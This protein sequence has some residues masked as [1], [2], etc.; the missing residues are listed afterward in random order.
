MAT[1]V[2][3]HP[4]AARRTLRWSSIIAFT[5]ATALAAAG[6]TADDLAQSGK[7]IGEEDSEP[8]SLVDSIE[9]LEELVTPQEFPEDQDPGEIVSDELL[10][11]GAAHEEA[12]LPRIHLTIASPDGDLKKRGETYRNKPNKDKRYQCV[13][14]AQGGSWKGFDEPMVVERVS[15]GGS[16]RSCLEE[17][18]DPELEVTYTLPGTTDL[19]WVYVKV[20]DWG[21]NIL[22]C[23]VIDPISWKTKTNSSWACDQQWLQDNGHGWNPMP[24]VRFTDKNKVVQVTDAVEAQ[25]IL[26]EYCSEGQPSC[27]FNATSQEVISPDESKWRL[28][29]YFDNCG[30][31]RA[32]SGKHI[33]ED[34]VGHLWSIMVGGSLAVGGGKEKTFTVEVKGEFEHTWTSERTY[35]A[36]V[37]QPVRWGWGNWFYAQDNY[38]HLTGQ[39]IVK[40]PTATY[41]MDDAEYDLPLG[42]VWT[43]S[44][45]TAITPKSTGSL[46]YPVQCSNDDIVPHDDKE[47]EAV[48]QN[49]PPYISGSTQPD[50]DWLVEHGATFTPS[51]TQQ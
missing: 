16:S 2:S 11:A 38:V 41:Q 36:R 15:A 34:S 32:E 19:A 43:D 31:T 50:A 30:S 13:D 29:S 24:K 39:F 47:R 26:D 23:S 37:E 6:C 27:T 17:K 21:D 20:P 22:K 44:N 8:T 48:L 10:Q 4:H 9:P 46:A 25:R 42:K 40:T 3:R 5:A 33:W 12:R 49:N 51:Q 14:N 35:T 7:V 45:G 1:R 28:L 18:G